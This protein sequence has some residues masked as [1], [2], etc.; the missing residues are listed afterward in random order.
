MLHRVPNRDFASSLRNIKFV[1]NEDMVGLDVQKR[2]CI[3]QQHLNNQ[4]CYLSVLSEHYGY[5]LVI[6]DESVFEENTPAVRF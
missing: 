6:H 1:F 5:M 4:A 3:E 2:E